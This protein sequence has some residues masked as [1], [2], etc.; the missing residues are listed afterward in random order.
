MMPRN[1]DGFKTDKSKKMIQ[2]T[3]HEGQSDARQ[4]A[5]VLIV[6]AGPAFR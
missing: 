4:N 2:E 6:G 1:F 3:Q 5:G